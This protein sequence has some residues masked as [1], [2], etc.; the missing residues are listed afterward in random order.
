[1]QQK[2][3]VKDLVDGHRVPSEM[4]TRYTHKAH[5]LWVENDVAGLN[6]LVEELEAKIKLME[7]NGELAPVVFHDVDKKD[8]SEAPAVAESKLQDSALFLN[9]G[10]R[11]FKFDVEDRSTY[12]QAAGWQSYLVRSRGCYAVMPFDNTDEPRRLGCVQRWKDEC[13][14]E[15]VLLPPYR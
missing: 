15:Y 9:E 7:E 8:V 4:Y 6:A 11:S 13:V 12:P 10:L 14:T 5:D 2:D 3:Y 1:M